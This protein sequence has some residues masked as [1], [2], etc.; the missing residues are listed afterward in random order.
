[1]ADTP[2]IVLHNSDPRPLAQWLKTAFPKAD[3]R[4]CDSY[5]ALPALVE[6]YRPEIV[7]SVRFAGT[8]GFPRD[9]LFGPGG[10][11][12]IANGGAG[13]DH[14][15]QWD[16]DKT[17]VTNAAGVA[18]DMMAEYVLG[19]FLH[20]TLDISGL[21]KDKA[22]R[23]WDSS[24]TVRPL[25]GQTLLIVGLG[26]SG[27]AIAARAKAFD[28]TVLGTRAHPREMEHVDEVYSANDLPSL[29]PRADFIVVAT[30]LTQQTRGL[31]CAGEIAAMRPGVI[32]ADISRGGVV[33]QAALQAALE[34]G[35]VAAA[36]LDVFEA[37]PLPKTSELWDLHNVIL[38][39]HCSSVYEGWEK[40]SFDLF[41]ENLDRWIQGAA[42]VNIVNPALG[43]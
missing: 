33:D 10:P 28:M 27:Q 15:G 37:E 35:H 3:Y 11:R 18:A 26:H 13:T 31:L 30:P 24:R 23:V 19:G 21:Q 14:Y 42:L 5:E 32:F 22:A 9:A 6:S 1:M 38:S 41:I 34:T 16:P 2:R 8:V 36:V 29:L 12:W 40:A 17:T 20:F 4:E 25:A 7:Y 39:P 43:Y